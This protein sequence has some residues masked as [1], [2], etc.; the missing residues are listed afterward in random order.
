MKFIIVAIIL[1]ILFALIIDLLYVKFDGLKW[2]ND[3]DWIY[4]ILMMVIALPVYFKG[5]F[6]LYKKKWL[7]VILA[8]VSFIIFGLLSA[9][10]GVLF[11]TQILNAPL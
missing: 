4:W 2:V 1:Q 10:L 8:I 6:I 11:H 9:I 3:D 7:A 5:Y